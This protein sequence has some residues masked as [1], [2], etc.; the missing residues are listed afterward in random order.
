MPAIRT[1]SA[2]DGRCLLASRV[3]QIAKIHCWR[4]RLDRPA[5][6]LEVRILTRRNCHGPDSGP[7]KARSLRRQR[8]CNPD[9]PVDVLVDAPVPFKHDVPATRSMTM[10]NANL[11]PLAPAAAVY[12]QVHRTRRRRDAH[13][14]NRRR[15]HGPTTVRHNR[16]AVRSGDGHNPA[17]LR[18]IVPA[19][20][21]MPMSA[22]YDHVP[23]AIPKVCTTGAAN[24]P[25]FNDNDG[26]R[27]RP[28]VVIME[29]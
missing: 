13:R 15:S 1:Q 28:V 18:Q 21:P 14:A 5:Q 12:V 6:T 11:L 25:L 10:P 9:G 3:C 22:P 29:R 2:S 26:R 27:R 16:S 23:P 4:C 8:Q 19:A 20:R 24:V 7:W 17:T